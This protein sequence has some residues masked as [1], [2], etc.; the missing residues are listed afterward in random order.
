MILLIVICLSLIA[1]LLMLRKD[2]RSGFP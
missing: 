2:L 1:F